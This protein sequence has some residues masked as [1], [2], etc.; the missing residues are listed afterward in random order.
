M[1]YYTAILT[2]PLL[3]SL[4]FIDLRRDDD[5]QHKTTAFKKL[6][7]LNLN[8]LL[9]SQNSTQ[10]MQCVN[11]NLTP[12]NTYERNFICVELT[13]YIHSKEHECV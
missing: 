12:H 13:I 10:L 4:W 3:W 7:T 1:N 6:L 2:L 8:E 9:L 5:T 11:V